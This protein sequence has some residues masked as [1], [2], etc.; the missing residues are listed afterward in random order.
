MPGIQDLKHESFK[1]KVKFTSKKYRLIEGFV[2]FEYLLHYV[3]LF[4]IL[5]TV[6]S[7]YTFDTHQKY[8]YI[9]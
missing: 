4:N 7:V 5:H 9:R 8:I 6:L 3:Y 2:T 1:F